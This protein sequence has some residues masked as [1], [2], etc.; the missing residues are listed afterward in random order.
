[1]NRQPRDKAPVLRVALLDSNDRS[2]GT[3][4]VPADWTGDQISQAAANLG[5]VD[6]WS[7]QVTDFTL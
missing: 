4:L 5:L 2:L 1:M 6:L 7:I 3:I